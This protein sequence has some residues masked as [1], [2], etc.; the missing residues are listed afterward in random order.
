M[1]QEKILVVEDDKDIVRLLK[2]NLEKEGYRV[3]AV[4]DG[5]SG[6]AAARKERPELLILDVM[7]PKL[8]GF[9][10]LKMV[11][12]ETR[13]PVLMLTARKEEVDRVLGLELG[14]DDYVPKPFNPRELLARMRAV[15]RRARP[16]APADR[17]EVG[18]LLIDVPAHRAVRAG[19]E[20]P[21]TSFEF[22]VLVALARRAGETV[23]REELAGVVLPNGQGYDPSVDRTLDVHVSHLRH[24]LGDGGR[25][26]RLIRTVR[27]VGYV[28]VR[29]SGGA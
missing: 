27:G 7:I 19:Q 26:P 24:K 8:D 10:L 12:R 2:Y 9:E 23:T 15:L 14:A 20:V 6:L 28:L 4:S 29:A 1:A 3:I 16:R 18:D 21:L 25:E 13:A 5:E 22:R 11:R 17:I